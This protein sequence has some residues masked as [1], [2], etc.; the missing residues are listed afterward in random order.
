MK[1]ISKGEHGYL[2]YVKKRD[3][4]YILITIVFA[5]LVFVAGILKWKTKSN[6]ATVIAVMSF[7]PACKRIVNLIVLMPFKPMSEELYK[8]ISEHVPENAVAFTDT[9]FSSEQRMYKFEHAVLTNVGMYAYSEMGQV[10]NYDC[11][12]YLND[13]FERRGISCRVKIYSKSDDYINLIKRINSDEE[14]KN[15]DA[16]AFFKSLIV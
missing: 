2:S 14:F 13:G 1:K 7:L 5:V 6:I 9:V 12:T 15:D 3:L 10:K 16:K 11:D 4:R 8:K